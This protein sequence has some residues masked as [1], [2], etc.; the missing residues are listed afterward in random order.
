[1]GE[2]GKE[3]G[4]IEHTVHVSTPVSMGSEVIGSCLPLLL[5]P[6]LYESRSLTELG[7]L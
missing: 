6:L 5:S 4:K 7:P 1:M 3:G 2:G